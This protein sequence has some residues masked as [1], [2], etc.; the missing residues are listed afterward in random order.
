ML[1]AVPQASKAVRP[2]REGGT[3]IAWLRLLAVLGLLLGLL[4]IWAQSAR[5]AATVVFRTISSP[6]NTFVMGTVDLSGAITGSSSSTASS[7]PTSTAFKWTNTGGSTDCANL[8]PGVDVKTQ[9]FLPGHFCVAKVILR[10]MNPASVDAWMRIR[11]VRLT[12]AGTASTDALNDRLRFYMSEYAA[13]TS[14]TASDYQATDCTTANFK[15]VAVPGP[16]SSTAVITDVVNPIQGNRTALTTLGP[17][18]KNVGIH[19]GLSVPLDPAVTALTGQGLG[20]AAGTSVSPL[21]A[22]MNSDNTAPL[23]RNSFNLVGNDERKNPKSLATPLVDAGTRPGG[24]NAEAELKAN[25]SRYYCV[26]IFYP[27]DTDRTVANGTGDNAAGAGTVTY[28][29]VVDAYQQ[30]GHTNP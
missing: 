24:T 21:E 6:D 23:T 30:A 16:A 17:S 1:M 10:N 14:R 28:H 7:L 27:S 4:T 19:P 5:S 2:L 25:T 20:L 29:L 8:L 12:A 26:A 9:G 15:P 18:G 13:G 11:L 22:N 3:T